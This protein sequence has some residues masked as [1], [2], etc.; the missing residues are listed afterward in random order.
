MDIKE[1][2]KNTLVELVEA[3]NE[4]NEEVHKKYPN[5]N[6]IGTITHHNDSPLVRSG[7]FYY[8][9]RDCELD[10]AVSAT[11]SSSKEGGAKIAVIDI[12]A[13]KK[14]EE[15]NASRVKISIPI[16]FLSDEQKNIRGSK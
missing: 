13:D 16:A 11:K 8:I 4:A 2:I 6:K 7:D 9:V 14:V 10:I 1:F 12:G 5:N 3:V 15:K